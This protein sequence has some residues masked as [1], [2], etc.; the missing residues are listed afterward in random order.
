MAVAGIVG[1]QVNLHGS[2]SG[3]LLRLVLHAKSLDMVRYESACPG[4]C[5]TTMSHCHH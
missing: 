2:V 5:L 4:Q 1:Y 3:F